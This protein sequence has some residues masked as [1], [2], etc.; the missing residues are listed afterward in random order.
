M[1]AAVASGRH[2]NDRADQ[3]KQLRL[4]MA[5]VSGK[6][7]S[8]AAGPGHDPLPE[9]RPGL[10]VPRSLTGA[11]PAGLPRGTVSVLSGARS[12][13]LQLV[14]A[15]T[16]AGGNAAIVGLPDTG[17]L[18]AAELGADLSRLGVVPD[19]GTDPVE[20]AAVLM[21][22]MDLVVLGLAGQSIPAA[23]TRVV[24]A[25]ARQHGCALLVTGGAWRGAA[26]RLDARVCGYEMTCGTA[27]PGFGRIGA[28]RLEVAAGERP[29]G[30]TRAG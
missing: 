12:L 7:G 30:H 1:T 13:V 24:T 4:R 27:I 18:A 11:F 15:V 14:A 9:S 28:V 26:R 10:P 25:R 19:P 6:A 17:L 29:A 21:E 16:A 20:V 23:R 22:G 3:L 5:A 2:H 8:G